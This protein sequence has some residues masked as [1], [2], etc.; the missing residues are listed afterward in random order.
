MKTI[1]VTGGAGFMGSNFVDHVRRH[2]P[3]YRVWVL[4]LLTYAGN[5]RNLAHCQE[6]ERFKFWYGNIRNAELVND[7]M[8]GS[9]VV[10]H[11]AAETHV[12]RSLYDTVT[13]FETQVLGTQCLANAMLK[14]SDRTKLFVHISSSEVYGSVEYS[15]MDENHPLNPTSPYAGAKC[16]ADRLLYSYWVT[17]GLPVVLVRPFNNYGPRQHLEKV[18]PRF[19]TSALVGEPLTVH[20]DGSNTR[21]WLWVEDT[22]RAVAKLMEIDPKKV[23]GEAVNLG[24][25]REIS[26]LEIA[27]LVLAKI[28]KPDSMLRYMEERPGQVKR[29]HSSTEKAAR[30]ID[31]KAEMRFE[32]GL[33]QTI[34]W[35]QKNRAWWEPQLWM[36]TIPVHTEDGRTV[37]Y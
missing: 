12:S 9:D 17:Y 25:D 11:F 21:D 13:C 33:D 8:A 36:R 15:P 34:E 32:E 29:H 1:L 35:Y 7:L 5:P 10:V 37:L 26:V 23:A 19:I 30:L 24:T 2:F 16:G 27:K 22:A 14:H 3:D 6:G 18:I 20:G 31:W 28:G 4:D